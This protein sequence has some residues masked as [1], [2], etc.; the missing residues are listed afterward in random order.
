MRALRLGAAG[1][2]GGAC[3]R[4]RP[5]GRRRAGVAGRARARRRGVRDR[6]EPRPVDAG[7]ASGRP[8][9][10]RCWGPP[11]TSRRA[12]RSR[13]YQPGRRPA[14]TSE[15]RAR[16]PDR[17]RGGDQRARRVP[18]AQPTRQLAAQARTLLGIL[19]FSE[20]AEGGGISQT[21]AAIADFT[22]AVRVD[23]GDTAAKFDLEL[24]LRLSAAHGHR[25]GTGPVNAFGNT[26]HAGSSGGVARQRLLMSFLTPLA[27][28]AALAVLLPLGAAASRPHP[29]CGRGRARLGLDPP[30]R[31]WVGPRIAAAAAAVALLGLA[32]AQPVLSE[33]AARVGRETTSRSSSCSTPRGRWPPRSRRPRRRGWPGQSRR[34]RGC[35]PRS[36]RCRPAWPRSRTASCLTCCRCPISRAS[37]RSSSAAVDDR[38]SAAGHAGRASP[39]SYAALDNI[40]TGNYFDSGREA[41]RDRAS[42]RW[43]EQP[44][45][46]ETAWLTSSASRRGTASSRSASGTATRRSSTRT[47]S[48]SRATIPIPPA[49]V[50]LGAARGRARRTLLRGE[51]D[52]RRSVISPPGRRPRAGRA[53]AWGARGS[54]ALAPYVAGLA[55][56]LLVVGLIPGGLVRRCTLALRRWRVGRWRDVA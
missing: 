10:E 17:A 28:L 15:R 22:D 4:R 46:P 5:A 38:R 25:R 41:P 12:R 18:R 47:D 43:R 3:G 2:S 14:A 35:A 49:G 24:L 8:R 26:G 33:R 55:L 9:G 20:A 21:D 50:L 13:R 51:P 16:G 23:P 7:D 34:R 1:R 19:T 52:R 32:A 42:H 37:T 29:G 53:G 45:R 54:T 40:A 27:A 31:W 44:V 30:P 36:P 6:S 48:A 39:P 56:L 11:T